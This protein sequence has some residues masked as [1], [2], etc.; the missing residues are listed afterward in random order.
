MTAILTILCF[1]VLLSAALH[2]ASEV[3]AITLFT[4]ASFAGCAVI[5]ELGVVL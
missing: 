2:S 1:L 4:S 5:L 3:G